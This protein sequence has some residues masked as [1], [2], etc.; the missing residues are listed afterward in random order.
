MGMP[1][2]DP[3]LKI[4]IT[5]ITERRI[6][7]S[8]GHKALARRI[9]EEIWNQGKMDV[10]DEIYDAHYVT[11]GHGIDLPSGPDGFKQLVSVFR[12]AFP[13]IHFTIEDQIAEGDKVVTRWT[14]RSTHKGELMGIPA[15]GQQ[16]M[17][18]GI[19]IIQVAAGKIVEGWNNWDRMDMMQQIGA[20][21]KMR[22]S[23][24]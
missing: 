20:V 3:S 2:F 6:I 14:S 22:K 17:T 13:D 9:F 11:H 15:T 4:L 16:V 12:K 23:G 19:S 5:R 21:P 10:A 18:A 1:Q 7:M 8:E 24:E